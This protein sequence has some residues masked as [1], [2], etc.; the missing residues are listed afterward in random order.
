MHRSALGLGLRTALAL[1]PF[2]F[3]APANAQTGDTAPTG[4]IGAGDV[5]VSGFSGTILFG[6]SLAPGVDPIDKTVIDVDGASLR[7]FDVSTLG[8]APA[9]KIVNPPL[10]FA[11]PAKDIGQVFGLVF[12]EGAQGESPNLYAGATSAYG[13]QIVGSDPDQE[14][15]PVRLKSGAPGARFM[16]GLFGSLP[17][18][19]PGTIWKIDGV[20]GKATALADTAFTGVPNSG[21][22]LG[23]LAFDPNS[24][25]LYASDLD[26]GEIHRFAL[27]YNAADLGQFDHGVT[28]RP[29][30]GLAAVPDDGKRM[31][32]TSPEFNPDDITT[33]GFTQPE[34]R[35]HGLTVHGGRLYYAVDAGP[36]IW[37]VGLNE[38][39]S[40]S[41]DVRSEL[42]V[43]ADRKLPVTSIVFDSQ[44]RMILAQRGAQKNSY[45]YGPFVEPGATQVLR[46][47]KEEPDDPATPGMWTPEP[48]SYAIGFAKDTT[49]SSGGVSL[50]YGYRSDGTLDLD[51]CRGTL[52]ATADG[53]T[54][55]GRAHGLQ[56]N[57]AGLVRPFADPLQ[58]SAFVEYDSR[59][60]K[61]DLL[62]HVGAVAVFHTCAGEGGPP[63]AGAPPGYPPAGGGAFPPVGGGG[64]FPPI[65]GGEPPMPPG[66]KLHKSAVSVNCNETKNC[67]YEIGIEN[68]T[69]KPIS[70]PIV[71][72]DTL[73]AGGAPLNGA[74]IAGGP[75]PPWVCQSAP[76][77]FTCIHPGP[78]PA[79]TTELLLLSFL[80]GPI[81]NVRE[82]KNCAILA[83][84]APPPATPV[85]A[86]IPV[87]VPTPA[88]LTLEKKAIAASCSDAGG[89]C[90]FEI[91]IAN[92]GETEFNGPIEFTDTVTAGG[93]FFGTT[94]MTDGFNHG[95]FKCAKEGQFFRCTSFKDVKIP[96]AGKIDH[97]VSFKLGSGTAANEI[98]NC[99]RLKDD[100]AESCATIPLKSGPLLRVQKSSTAV[101]CDPNCPFVIF[102]KNFG[103]TAFD[104]PLTITDTF[105]VAGTL[106]SAGA[107]FPGET[108]SCAGAGPFTCE[109]K[110]AKIAPGSA[111]GIGLSIKPAKALEYENCAEIAA[112]AGIADKPKGCATIRDLTTPPPDKPVPPKPELA[113]LT[114]EKKATGPSCFPEG[115]CNFAIIVKNT[116]TEP[117]TGFV[118]IED[119]L[120]DAAGALIVSAVIA[121]RPDDFKPWHCDNDGG[122]H[123]F[124]QGS[125]TIAPG[126][127]D[128]INV[129]FKPGAVGT[130]QMIENCA[131]ITGGAGPACA[132]IQL[133]P[134]P[135]KT[136][137]LTIETSAPPT[138]ELKGWCRFKVQVNNKGTGDYN[139][140]IEV[141]NNF[142]SGEG[143]GR[144]SAGVISQLAPGPAGIWACTAQDE[145]PLNICRR[146]PSRT[147]PPNVGE[148]NLVGE[149]YYLDVMPG[150]NWAKNNILQ[151]CA[152]LSH[153]PASNDPYDLK[154]P[155]ESCA[156]V[157]LDPFAVEIKKSGGE[158]CSPGGECR[159][160]LEI[161]NPGPILHDDPVTVTDNLAGLASAPIVSIVPAAGAKPFPCSPA[162]TEIPFS[163]SGHMRLEIGERHKYTMTVKLPANA[164][165]SGAF[166][167]CATIASGTA[168]APPQGGL[169]KAPALATATGS[170]P[171]PEDGSC[172]E[173]KLAPACAGGMELNADGRC[174]CPKGQK[175]DGRACAAEKETCPP[176]TTGT[177][178]DCKA[179][180]SSAGSDKSKA[181]ET[182]PKS[183]PVGTPPNC[184]P[185]GMEFKK[186]AC[187]CP[188][189][190]EL[191]KG[192]CRAIPKAPQKCPA[193]RPV[194]TP[195]NCCPKGTVFKNGACR[196]IQKAPQTCP[197]NRPVGTPPNCCPEGT[198]YKR[199]AC[200]AIACPPGTVG[201]PP[202]CMKQQ[203][204]EKAREC[205]PGYRVLS[206]PNKYGAYCEQIEQAPPKCPAD[207]PVGSP[208]N[209]CPQGTQ[210]R[211]GACYPLNC[212]PGWT[213]LPPD[214][215]PP[216]QAPPP[217][218][219]KC[220]SYMMGTPPDCRCPSG[221]M[222]PKC[223]QVIVR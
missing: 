198:E 123:F 5:A 83:A 128:T 3:A 197:P 146:L 19:S 23:G 95:N 68:T 173:V 208:P 149:F 111:T 49:S 124:C 7:I 25:N 182:C 2:L 185:K 180:S 113:Q 34:R 50:Q 213:G 115:P 177:P 98:K 100:G 99:A 154:N 67:A 153:D 152:Q 168:A 24:R 8:G 26:T 65:E 11:V 129:G 217:P 172:H 41:G 174:A 207:R 181:P 160:D 77:K 48:E 37:S 55:E 86:T 88:K 62:G 201:V 205:P 15:S 93:G 22:G 17:G 179:P 38:D 108:W 143:P 51:V 187:R 45:D 56:L 119:T 47:A 18:G 125:P 193:D 94:E 39:G 145:T 70:G 44:G 203:E 159:F 85:C 109:N 196:E 211:K 35:V 215:Q 135:A 133:D 216:A 200:R 64:A 105:S 147:V 175:W 157:R 188:E 183:K 170:T 212:S 206:K 171:A 28:G 131:S 16:A 186:G 82:V 60:D 194:G 84:A 220:P 202:L 138:C 75:A 156:S 110:T 140:K 121:V 40:F 54:A 90:D 184:C 12:D 166:K 161:F 92:A 155:K 79:N 61:A 43:E 114:I 13:I 136:P 163:C 59:Q 116:G 223:D 137:N 97:K 120:K 78:I 91:A 158:S 118:N 104:G 66:L 107:L 58:Q 32:I 144:V 204:K 176:E 209:C 214:C 132:K 219:A 69:D 31:E 74:K 14:G 150:A 73:S 106:V 10:K 103:N 164:P 4:A 142:F 167:N 189:G 29:A 222:G 57:D 178:P 122:G 165:A 52:A 21:P 72:E 63:V 81:G 210:F 191:K 117:F 53:L 46:Y 27:D 80:P 36:E 192:V 76:P 169:D 199:G 148:L 151:L 87:K 1:I 141:F 130:G 102:I 139:G 101:V 9:G 42:L 33:W 96:A 134:S 190:T 20:T 221:L 71:I 195:P 6:E 30:R 218:P 112:P 127:S 162:P 126:A 89:G